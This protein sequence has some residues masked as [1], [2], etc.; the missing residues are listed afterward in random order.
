VDERIYNA[1]V[2]NID[3]TYSSPCIFIEIMFLLDNNIEYKICRFLREFV[4]ELKYLMMAT[5]CKSLSEIKNKSCRLDIAWE[6][7][8]ESVF[9]GS[10]EIQRIGHIVKNEFYDY[11]R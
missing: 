11:R 8:G 9:G 2:Q 5:D 4:D 3:I 6:C 7:N 1:V 10:Y